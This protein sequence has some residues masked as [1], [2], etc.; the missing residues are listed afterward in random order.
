MSL[1]NF[2]E[3][4]P[5]PRAWLNAA[6]D[7]SDERVERIIADS[8]E[9]LKTELHR[10]MITSRMIVEELP[11]VGPLAITTLRISPDMWSTSTVGRA[12]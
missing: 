4:I 8:I 2:L 10:R 9:S 7:F 6:Q 11:T 5:D 1:A 12:S 3:S